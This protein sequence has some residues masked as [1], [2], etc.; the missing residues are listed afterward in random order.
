MK[1]IKSDLVLKKDTTFNESIRVEGNIRCEGGR[2]DLTVKGDVL[3]WDISA[4][5]VSARDISALDISAL[6]ISA[7]D[8]SYY[9]FCI[10]YNKIK[11]NSIKGKRENSFHKA[12]DG[13][14]IIKG[15]KT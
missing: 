15:A 5:N 1:V 9:A 4:G 3:A 12:L 7:W 10:A 11:C 14:I 13:K 6:D 8:I 2:H